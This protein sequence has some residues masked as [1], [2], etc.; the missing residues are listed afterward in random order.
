MNLAA[1]A[2][3]SSL[4]VDLDQML[5]SR[6]LPARST[7][8]VWLAGE[9]PVRLERCVSR[10]CPDAEWR[11]YTD[12]SRIF[13]AIAR[14]PARDSVTE[15]CDGPTASGLGVSGVGVSGVGV[16]GRG[17]SM[18]VYLLDGNA[19]VYSAGSWSYSSEQ[20]WWLDAVLPPSYDPQHGWW[21]EAVMASAAAP[22]VPKSRTRPTRAPAGPSLTRS[23]S[24]SAGRSA[25]RDVWTVTARAE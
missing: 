12:G 23:A 17:A 16:S 10:L 22:T 15:G 11:A 13:F 2:R 9:L 14:R 6:F 5:N 1:V 21:L 3:P 7:S 19:A 25:G 20:G 24:R 4:G 8:R 18:D